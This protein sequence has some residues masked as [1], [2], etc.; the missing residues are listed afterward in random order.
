[1]P[2]D[3][4]K[5][6]KMIWLTTGLFSLIATFQFLLLPTLV[7]GFRQ[8][9]FGLRRELFLLVV[10][11]KISP[12]EPAYTH[13]RS[14]MNGVLRFAHH[15]TLTR[16]LFHGTLFRKHTLAYAQRLKEDLA[17]V[18]NSKL[19]EQLIQF[20]LRLGQEIIRHVL[21]SS[22][23]AW[24][25]TLLLSPILLGIVVFRGFRELV[26]LGQKSLSVFAEHLSVQGIE[27]QAE[28]LIIRE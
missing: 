19:R 2:F 20:R 25:C 22:P 8:R 16:L 6:A 4:E 7:A 27:A 15:L 10:Q 5:L 24:I 3:M 11:N 9:I 14:T 28:A 23:L 21:L 17:S 1:M 13:L 12:E 18:R 26:K